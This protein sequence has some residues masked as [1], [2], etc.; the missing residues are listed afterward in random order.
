MV[1]G[2]HSVNVPNLV[3]LELSQELVQ[4]QP[5]SAVEMIVLD[6]QHRTAI[7]ILVQSM[8]DGHPL[9]PAPRPAAVDSSQELVHNQHQHT[10]E[11]VVLDRPHSPAIQQRVRSGNLP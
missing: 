8:A 4:T 2:V 5:R 9:A 3:E 1:D 10:G 11:T 6:P 7:Q